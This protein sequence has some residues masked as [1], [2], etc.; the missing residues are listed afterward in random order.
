M[1]RDTISM[2]QLMAVLWA[3][4]L[5]PAAELLPGSAARA[6]SLSA[7][8]VVGAGVGML[9]SGWLLWRLTRESG[10]LARGVRARFGGLAGKV[11]LFIY[12]VWF[13]LLFTL[14]LE[15]AARRL[16]GGGQR[17]GAIWFFLVV[18]GGMALWFARGSLGRF[19]R[20]GELMFVCLMVVG[21]VVFALALGQVRGENLLTAREKSWADIPGLILH[22]SSV[23]G[24]GL[25]AAFLM[26]PKGMDAAGRIWIGWTAA[27]C[28]LLALAQVVMLGVYGP[29]LTAR[30]DSPFFQLAKGVAVEGAFQRVESVVAAVWTFSDLI[31]LGGIL[32]AV[33]NIGGVLWPD[34]PGH[35][36]V[37]VSALSGIV[38][39]LTLS[40]GKYFGMIRL[41]W[42]VPAG[43]VLLGI[44]GP[45]LAISTK[46]P[47]PPG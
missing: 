5:G 4:L 39:G 40:G 44:I 6:G 16:M 13:Q 38:L 46:R 3:G 23:L 29:E 34:A 28:L 31:L 43:G 33:R 11:I 21:A 18:L 20:T 10:G 36:V 19:G 17:D 15:G 9:L 8:G 22:G 30:L 14:R 37:T 24:Y 27:G 7:L 41:P 26:E 12:M 47:K 35:S 25:Y 45:L 42:V 2:R 32:L 1:E